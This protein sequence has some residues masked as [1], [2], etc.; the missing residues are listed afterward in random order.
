[1]KKGFPLISTVI[2]IVSAL[3]FLV[4]LYATFQ[5]SLQALRGQ[6]SFEA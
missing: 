4:P 5:F 3:F 2:V 6:L 1:M